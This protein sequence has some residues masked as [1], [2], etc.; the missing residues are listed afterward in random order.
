MS[1]LL[2]SV[3][4]AYGGLDRWR[5]FSSLEATIVTGGKLWS[6]KVQPQDDVRFA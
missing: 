2:E 3:L 5:E 4:D 6:L 1:T